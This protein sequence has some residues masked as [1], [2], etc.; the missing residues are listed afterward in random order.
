MTDKKMSKFEEFKTDIKYVLFVYLLLIV[1]HLIFSGKSPLGILKATA[2][3]LVL[4]VI[5]IFLTIYV[6]VPKLPGFAW[7]ALTAFI[8]T[9]PISPAQGF[10][11]SALESYSFSLLT[12]PLMALAGVAVGNQIDTLKRVGWKIVVVGLIVMASTY[13]FSAIIAQLV[14]SGTGSI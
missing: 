1:L 14:L 12:I 6:T 4:V 11:L 3:S 7:G 5:S 10:I 8:L 2:M 9:L 13:F